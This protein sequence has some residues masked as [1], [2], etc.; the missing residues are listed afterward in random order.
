MKNENMERIVMMT[1]VV[2]KK[3]KDALLSMLLESGIHLVNTVYG[4][5]TFGAGYLAN[6]L[7]L[8]PEKNRVVITCVS[9][10]L[11]T[12]AIFKLLVEKFNF[13]KPHTG[14]AFTVPITRVSY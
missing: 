4:K 8:V 10:Y 5:S 3:Q 7:A 6:T 9:T 13:D 12:E 1:I 11:K 2:E 14:I